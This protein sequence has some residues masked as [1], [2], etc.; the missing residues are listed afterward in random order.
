[1]S[2]PAVAFFNNKSGVGKTSLVYH[3]AWMFEEL[4]VRVVAADLDPQAN[5]TAAFSDE[6]EIQSL[7]ST[8]A[9]R[10]TVY[11]ALEPIVKGTGDIADPSLQTIAPGLSLLAGDLLLAGFEDNLSEAWPRSLLG[12]EAQLRVTSAFSRILRTAASQADASLILID[13]GPNLG[14]L[15]RAAL[16]AA[17]WVVT[18]LAPDLFSLQGLTNLGPTLERWRTEWKQCLQAAKDKALDLELPAGEMRPAGYVVL[19]HSI[20]LDRPTRAYDRWIE[21][22]PTTYHRDVLGES[23][24]AELT[25][26]TDP[27]A[28]ALLKHYRTLMAL[29]QEARKPMFSLTAADG[30]SGAHFTA[31]RSAGEDFRALA[32]RVAQRIGLDLP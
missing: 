14:S 17:D 18:P 11:G 3:L 20:R 8:K 12:Q 24:V 23:E 28:L 4:G 21:L 19:Q 2:V 7:W 31:S 1:M 29:A 9:P 27:F 6:S 32:E 26:Q 13:L 15:N 5:L 10:L 25:V 30:A 22:I 16:F